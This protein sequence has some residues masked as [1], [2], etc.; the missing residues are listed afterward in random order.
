MR[1]FLTS[2]PRN[3]KAAFVHGY[4][5]LWHLLAIALTGV[6]VLSGFDWAYHEYFRGTVIY[7]VLFTAGA[8]GFLLPFIL[9]PVLIAVGALRKDE[10]TRLAGYAIA[11]AEL[12]GLLVSWFYKALTGRAHPDISSTTAV[13]D[14]TRQFNFGFLEGG[15]FWGW[16]SSHTAVAFAMS[17]A[18]VVMYRHRP[19]IVYTALAYALY[20]G[21]GASMTFH[22]L[23]DFVAGAILGSLVGIVVGRHFST[24]RDTARATDFEQKKSEQRDSAPGEHDEARDDESDPDIDR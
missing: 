22:W 5:P 9:P 1:A 21:L 20:I 11:Q 19:I 18:F 7:A 16:P 15:V 12:I 4:N 6:L 10:R 14:V 8:V 2:F 17:V 24:L 13:M 3:L 23:S